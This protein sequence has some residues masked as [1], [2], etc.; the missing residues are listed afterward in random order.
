MKR[1]GS[2]VFFKRMNNKISWLSIITVLFFVLN[3]FVISFGICK[4]FMLS[5]K[6]SDVEYTLSQLIPSNVQTIYSDLQPAIDFYQDQMQTFIW[7]LGIVFSAAGAI[8]AIFG[9]STRKSIEEKYNVYYNKLISAKD[10]EIYKK[11]IVI[12]YKNKSES[13]IDFASELRNRGYN[14]KHAHASLKDLADTIKFTSIIVYYR[15]S[16]DDMLYND[17]A[18]MCETDHIHCIIY[19][20]GEGFPLPKEFVQK[21]MFYISI[22]NQI[23][24]LRESLYTLLYL[25]P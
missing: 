6:I 11:E 8:L 19:S 21:D 18:E 1:S 24:K 5:N 23:T 2:S 25:A 4:V 20:T 10:V 13:I 15:N 9:I 7:L 16:K 3:L 17:I 22:C 12:L 14:I